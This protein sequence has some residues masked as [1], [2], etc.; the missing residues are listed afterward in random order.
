[1][2]WKD[3]KGVVDIFNN[4]AYLCIQKKNQGFKLSS[5]FSNHEIVLIFFS[6]PFH[7]E[8]QSLLLAHKLCIFSKHLEKNSVLN[9]HI[10]F[11]LFTFSCLLWFYELIDCSKSKDLNSHTNISLPILPECIIIC[12]E[13]IKKPLVSLTLWFIMLWGLKEII[14]IQN[15]CEGTFF[16]QHERYTFRQSLLF[17][18]LGKS[19]W[20]T[21]V[22]EWNYVSAN[23]PFAHFH[24]PKLT[25]RRMKVGKGDFLREEPTKWLSSAK[26][27]ALE[28]CTQLTLH[29]LSMGYLLI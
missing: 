6:K 24:T 3:C 17:S 25:Q 12:A 19:S 10:C 16:F 14:G 15:Y 5:L 28:T 4:Y 21:Q 1:M 2:H 22:N 8:R 26:W 7:L 13:R 20:K 18:T 11:M 27:S 23:F 29:G 9:Y